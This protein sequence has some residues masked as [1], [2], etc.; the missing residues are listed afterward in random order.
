MTDPAQIAITSEYV[1]G[2]R[3]P[4]G[5]EILPPNTWHSHPISTPAE[6]A[7]IV[8]VLREAAKNIGEAEDELLSRYQWTRREHQII[9]V[10]RE[11][12]PSD[13]F[14][15]DHPEIIEQPFEDL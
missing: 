9:T 1:V 15:I 14:N 5:Q 4:N 8:Q 7:F 10:T 2:L 3:L 6:R 11:I 13:N 12:E